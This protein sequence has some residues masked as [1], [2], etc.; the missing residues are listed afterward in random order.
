MPMLVVLLIS[1]TCLPFI[2]YGLAFHTSLG[3]DGVLVSIALCYTV[4]FTALLTYVVV[5]QPHAAGSWT[6]W[7]RAAYSELP[8][9][10]R[11]AIPGAVMLMLEWW[12]VEAIGFMA[13][14]R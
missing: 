13:G 3:F 2:T 5:K 6:G 12:A 11:V 1:A 7:S 9:Y 14:G 8:E 4:N 10:L